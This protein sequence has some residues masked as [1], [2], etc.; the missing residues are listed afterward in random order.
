MKNSDR[1]Y[2]LLRSKESDNSVRTSL[3]MPLIVMQIQSLEI[4]RERFA[5]SI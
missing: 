5:G 3:G 4:A 2:F 1:S